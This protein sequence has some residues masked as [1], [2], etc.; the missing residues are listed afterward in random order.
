MGGGGYPKRLMNR[1]LIAREQIHQGE[2]YLDEEFAHQAQKVLRLKVGDEILCLDQEGLTYLSV[3]VDLQKRQAKAK[4]LKTYRE[5][6]EPDLHITL[7]QGLPKGERWDYILQ[8]CT[9]LGVSSFI[10]VISQRSM[11]RLKKEEATKK[12]QRWLKIVKEAVEQSSRQIVPEIFP[13]TDLASALASVR[14]CDLIVAAWEQEKK[15]SLASLLKSQNSIKRIA[16]VIGPEGGFSPEEAF[17]FESAGAKAVSLGPRILR[18]E[19]AATA[20]CA[21]V[22]YQFQQMEVK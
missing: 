4:I 18:S 13:V 5:N 10:P 3:L 16:L 21:I 9:E 2:I 19:T 11:V 12:H 7:I 6:N 8:K 20:L 22:L 1:F 17:L 14:E 15:E